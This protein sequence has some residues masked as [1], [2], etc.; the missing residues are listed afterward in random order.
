MD[1]GRWPELDPQESAHGRLGVTWLLPAE[2]GA[3]YSSS[4][5][6]PESP[7]KLL[8]AAA[9][10]RLEN[11]ES[12]WLSVISVFWVFVSLIFVSPP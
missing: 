8:Q 12:S 5:S 10:T 2:T 7:Q 4:I 6:H 3:A 1:W 11:T 9:R